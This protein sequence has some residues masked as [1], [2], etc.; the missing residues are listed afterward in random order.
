MPQTVLETTAQALVAPGKGLLAA[1][2]SRATIGRRF[3]EQGSRGRPG[4]CRGASS[5]G[6]GTQASP[7]I[8]LGAAHG[9]P[10]GW[11]PRRRGAAIPV[12]HLSLIGRHGSDP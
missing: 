10:G 4:R 9:R 2:E 6:A 7:R 8:T 3:A 12:G 11:M 1:D 5:R